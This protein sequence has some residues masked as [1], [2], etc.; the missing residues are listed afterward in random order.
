RKI[1]DIWPGVHK[2]CVQYTAESKWQKV[3][4][5]TPELAKLWVQ[6]MSL[7]TRTVFK[8]R[9]YTYAHCPHPEIRRKLYEVLS[10]EDIVDPRVGMNHRQLLVTS[11][12]KATGQSLAD[13]QNVK[14]LATTLFTFEM[15]YN[16][17][18]RSWEEGFATSAGH[19]RF[20][21]ESGWFA[22]QAKR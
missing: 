2:R 15:F 7:W 5:I 3:E 17:S 4:K 19:E 18:S 6:Q 21:Q 20:L 22:H 9:G 14:P 16:L 13:L 8:A 12:G 1:D 10:E 11:L